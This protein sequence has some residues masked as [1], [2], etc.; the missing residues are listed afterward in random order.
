M[1][2]SVLV[3]LASEDFVDQAKQL[4]SSVYFNSGWG[5]DYMLLT[6]EIPESKLKWFRKKGIYIKKCKPIHDKKLGRWSPI[7]ATK[8]YL[9]SADLKKWENVVFLDADIIVR[10]NLEPLN[11]IKGFA[12]VAHGNKFSSE[13]KKYK[14]KILKELKRKYNFKEKVFNSGVLAFDTS[15]IKE[16]TFKKLIFL[17]KKYEKIAIGDEAIINLYFYKKWRKLDIT[18]N[19][20]PCFLQKYYTNPK[21]FQGTIIHFLYYAGKPWNLKNPF[22]KE[23]KENLERANEIDIKNPLQFKEEKFKHRYVYYKIRFLTK[24]DYFFNIDRRIGQIGIFTK[25]Y[26]PKL[27]HRLNK[28][29]FNK[30]E[31]GKKIT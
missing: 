20:V 19:I 25:K 8:L 16:N 3:T 26:H 10:K 24:I 17:L 27:Y 6:H 29:I 23:W 28:I 21:N 18:Y 9:F 5:G 30:D 14:S 13:F 15:I 2:K 11:E 1:K 7:V 31:G 12:A 4:F 22:Y